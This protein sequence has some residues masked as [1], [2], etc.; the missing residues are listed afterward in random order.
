MRCTTP[1]S[2]PALGVFTP[3]AA[4]AEPEASRCEGTPFT[5]RGVNRQQ[6]REPEAALAD[7]LH[8]LRYDPANPKAVARRRVYEQALQG[9]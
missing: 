4:E 8:V 7:T 5:A 2:H 1:Y 9:A 6:M 3:W